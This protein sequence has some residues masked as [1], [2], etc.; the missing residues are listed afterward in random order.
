MTAT[1]TYL[2][3]T[4]AAIQES[5]SDLATFAA[6]G[7]D[8]TSNTD[9]MLNRFK[10]WVQRAWKQIQ[11]DA[12]DWEFM[13]E[14]GVCNLDPGIMFYTNGAPVSQFAAG[15]TGATFNIY[16][17]DGTVAIPS[18]TA[19]SFTNLTGTATLTKPFGYFNIAGANLATPLNVALKPGAEYFTVS[20][21]VTFDDSV[22][23][24]YTDTSAG[25]LHILTRII[26]NLPSTMSQ[27]VPQLASITISS[28]TYPVAIWYFGVSTNSLQPYGN[29]L[30]I[31][32]N[33]ADL[34]T[35]SNYIN[36]TTDTT[37]NFVDKY[38]GDTLLSYFVTNPTS[39]FTQTTGTYTYSYN[40]A[41]AYIHSW[42]SFDFDEETQGGDFEED[43]QEI[44]Q[45]SFR[46][47]DF[48]KGAPTGEVPM[49]IIPWSIF[50]G[51]YDLSSAYPG[52]PRI[53]S[54]DDVGRYR[55]Y[56]VPYYKVTVKF[57][58]VRQPQILSAYNDLPRG[59]NDDFVDLIMW[60]ALMF[61]G[62][63]DEQPS[64]ETRAEKNYK[65]LLSRLENKN[66]PKFRLVP[67]RLY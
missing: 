14:Q 54:K 49:P 16:D 55:L 22:Q 5:G 24:N 10:T 59:I 67:K 27:T 3:I 12:Y 4:N 15:L 20:E 66:R 51:S 17:E 65:N 7:S 48:Y 58:Y 11:V 21:S 45:E 50:R 41:K 13:Q 34:A 19:A 40:A 23:F 53:I 63:Y 29:T 36:N 18:I 25:T 56:P 43:I 1:S 6:D 8:W 2:D 44:N 31:Y 28:V 60:R 9:A 46:I 39:G 32:C 42:K 38:S 57:D 64:I 47:V 62:Q 37:V 52:L 33:Q 30:Q 35:I 61:Y 26:N